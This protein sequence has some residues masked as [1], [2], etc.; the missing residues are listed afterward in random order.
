MSSKDN[1]EVA[2][3]KIENDKSAADAKCELKGTKRA[4]EVSLNLEYIVMLWFG[5]FSS[6][7]FQRCLGERIL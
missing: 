2:V 1:N 4:A 6:F 5:K 3:E 7:R